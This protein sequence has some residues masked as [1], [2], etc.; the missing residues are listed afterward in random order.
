MDAFARQPMHKLSTVT[1]I[2]QL[3]QSPELPVHVQRLQAL[4]QTE[5][6]RREHFY[7]ETSEQ[8]RNLHRHHPATEVAGYRLAL[9]QAALQRLCQRS[10]RFQPPCQGR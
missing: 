9:C 3:L 10:T 6:E 4:L 1:A 8:H 2:Q 5:R 7:D